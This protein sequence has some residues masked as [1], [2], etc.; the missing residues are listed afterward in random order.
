MQTLLPT[1]ALFE[2][3]PYEREFCASIAGSSG[4]AIALDQTLFSPTGRGQ[5]GDT[6]IIYAPP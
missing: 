1:Q 4:N 2:Q 3:T 6:G 5:P